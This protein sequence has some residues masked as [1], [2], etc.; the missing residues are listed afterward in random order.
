M[1][2][3][4]SNCSGNQAHY[5]ILNP[6]QGRNYRWTVTGG[7]FS[8]GNTG[9]DVNITWNM[10]Y[11]VGCV[12]LMHDDSSSRDTTFIIVRECVT[13][14]NSAAWVLDA[15]SDDVAGD[16]IYLSSL[17][18]SIPSGGSINLSSMMQA[19]GF[20]KILLGGKIIV[21]VNTNIIGGVTIEMLP[22]AS[23]I[24][25][26]GNTLNLSQ[27]VI[28]KAAAAEMWQGIF[29]ER[30]ASLII[31]DG[32]IIQDAY[33]G[34]Y[35]SINATVKTGMTGSRVVFNKNLYGIYLDYHQAPEKIDI[36]NTMF[37]CEQ[38]AYTRENNNTLLPPLEK[39]Y[40]EAGIFMY[41]CNHQANFHTIG[42]A[43]PGKENIFRN[44]LFGIMALESNTKLINNHFS[45]IRGNGAKTP[46]G[47]KCPPGTAICSDGGSSDQVYGTIIGGSEIP[48]QANVIENTD[49]GIYISR[50]M[51]ANIN[52][53]MLTECAV[54]GISL[55]D[56]LKTS[57]PTTIV[58]PA[59]L[60]DGYDVVN[61]TVNGV[62]DEGYH[63]YLFNNPMVRKNIKNNNINF[64]YTPEH[65]FASGI[66]VFDVG[67]KEHPAIEISENYIASVK[68]GIHVN[69][70]KG[71]GIQL[72]TIT[73]NTDPNMSEHN[74]HH[75][76]GIL[77][78]Y[79]ESS[80]IADNVISADNRENWWVDGI[81]LE[82]VTK[83]TVTCNELRR[84]GSGLF[85]SGNCMGTQ[86]IQNNMRRNYW[87][88]V[89]NH[90]ITGA[91]LDNFYNDNVWTGPYTGNSLQ[92][93]YWHTLNM[94]SNVYD[95][96]MNLRNYNGVFKPEPFFAT[97][98][99]GSPGSFLKPGENASIGPLYYPSG[100]NY[101]Q[102]CQPDT[103]DMIDEDIVQ[104][105][106]N[107]NFSFSD[108]V[109]E[110]Q[111]WMKY[112]LY[113]K[114]SGTNPDAQTAAWLQFTDSMRHTP[115]GKLLQVRKE[116]TDSVSGT[117]S[118]LLDLKSMNQAI[119]SNNDIEILYRGMNDKSLDA[120]IETAD[121]LATVNMM[122]QYP[123]GWIGNT[124]P[125]GIYHHT[126]GRGGKFKNVKALSG[127]D[128]TDIVTNG[129]YHYTG[130]TGG[131]NNLGGDST[132]QNG[133]YHYTGGTGGINNLGGDSTGQ[134]GIYHYTGGTGGINNLGGDS[135]GQNGIYHYTG[136]T[137][138]INNLGGDSTGQNG[139]YHYTGGTGGIISQGGDGSGQNG[140]YHHTGGRGG[141]LSIYSGGG[142]AQNRIYFSASNNEIN[143]L[144]I[145]G[146]Y[147]H[148]GNIGGDMNEP[149][150]GIYHHT[151]GR[152]GF[153][154]PG[155]G[156]STEQNG[157]YHHT[158]GRGGFI[159]PGNGGSDSTEQNGI[160]HHTGGRGGFISPVNGGG[161]TTVQNGIYHHT[162]GRGIISYTGI[163]HHTGG[164][165]GIMA[166][167]N[168]SGDTLNQNGIYHYT[169][170]T[171][172]INNLGGD[173]TGQNGIYHYTGGTG[174]TTSLPAGI[175]HYTGGTG[176]IFMTS[177]IYHYTG[178]TGGIAADSSNQENPDANSGNDSFGIYH[179]TGG[180]G[181]ITDLVNNGGSASGENGIYHHT[182][183][184]GGF[185][186]IFNPQNDNNT[187]NGIYHHTGGRGGFFSTYNPAEGDP[188]NNGIYHYTGGTG[189]I[190]NLGG[191]S[192]GQNGIYHYTGGTGGIINQGG[193]STGQ[194][195]I[196]H[197]T[198][199]RGGC[200][201]VFIPETN[202]S[203][204][205]SDYACAFDASSVRRDPLGGFIGMGKT[206][207]GGIYI[208]QTD[209]VVVTA[210]TGTRSFGETKP[211]TIPYRFTDQEI[212]QI[213]Q[214]AL[215][216]PFE[217]GPAVF[218]ARTL[219][220]KITGS[221]KT[222]LN[223]CETFQ[224]IN[225]NARMG[226][227]QA[228]P[229][230]Y[231]PTED[232]DLLAL[233]PEEQSKPKVKPGQIT[234]HASMVYPN[235][236]DASV[237]LENDKGITRIML[238]EANGKLVDIIQCN[239]E[240]RYVLPSSK[241]QKGL[242]QL[243]M[244]D[245]ENTSTV[246]KLSI[247]R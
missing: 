155:N 23:L 66:G 230:Q 203:N 214:T 199:G 109:A 71:A 101:H 81:R 63:I 244:W 96:P 136:G 50:S 124:S 138:G 134:N 106:L 198:G 174:I 89:N 52:G 4:L 93:N 37:S 91:N 97:S 16:E 105:I 142:N 209:T 116:M 114:L 156:D 135:T 200:I 15:Q 166:D 229:Y 12:A 147:H 5:K 233:Q 24:V 157:I 213:L 211:H 67:K 242:Y 77:S 95:T 144:A 59:N 54:N 36:Q 17:L 99:T 14:P 104:Q 232:Q 127:N 21:D 10:P 120:V 215:L 11:G 111:W 46:Q 171:G 193:D 197:H 86:L 42:N 210:P 115:S 139:I 146:V 247:I 126:G 117:V 39:R 61:N 175:Y 191:D 176:G 159:S 182:G 33:F 201:G 228:L 74:S 94:G 170:G 243:H 222:I 163:Y 118:A 43:T 240:K 227:P 75:G 205:P 68:K 84:T 27:Q 195:G 187:P 238:T 92:E 192:T 188:M 123:G 3:P 90:A 219:Y 161:D 122:H 25:A 231:D 9:N 189:G 119:M 234:S 88:M 100:L 103:G 239:G 143:T 72:N 185:F 18:D 225:V 64:Q 60:P 1:A 184:R 2:G 149:P 35:A 206:F 196:Y 179:Y 221:Y 83:S 168:P 45:G 40:M 31:N 178:G 34:A 29:V 245:G 130:G 85:V 154:S 181:G 121:E 133:I 32:C 48:S 26:E 173:S 41:R 53:N 69:G 169:G 76:A 49:Y 145:H 158:G 128:V 167:V 202:P 108:Y 208:Q 102:Y 194:N 70:L 129:I 164:R 38:S 7:S 162:G 235:P 73:L 80:N 165:G 186:A 204:R 79:C 236:A 241:Y 20:S 160:Y 151:G 172:G 150:N 28:M 6:V 237:N 56:N 212:D 218:I 44:G 148:R 125:N 132:G 140:I 180:T 58:G 47:A 216:C 30:D 224:P 22:G 51:M 112:Q 55:T 19:G 137:G 220:G 110:T 177:G 65:S 131:I 207:F 78:E 98:S 246:T 141:L 82:Y 226:N 152:G 217:H 153:I 57:T 8:G 62:G 107:G 13:P 183:G 223:P 190:N 87:G 113:E